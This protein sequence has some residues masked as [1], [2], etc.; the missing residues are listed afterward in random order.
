MRIEQLEQALDR[1]GGDLKRWPAP[2]RAEAEALIASDAKAAKLAGDTA[3]LD[4]LLADAVKPIA[5]DAALMGR[6][7]AGIGNGI[8]HE[9]ALRPTPRFAAWAGAAMIAFLTAGYVAGIALP[10]SQGEDA[11]AGL[12]FGNSRT[13]SDADTATDSGSVL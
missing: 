12:M 8:H 9:V 1:Y 4:A 5:V 2:L 6:I 10:A 13:T 7:V 11:L 3:Q